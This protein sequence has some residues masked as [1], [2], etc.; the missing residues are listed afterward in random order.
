MIDKKFPYKYIYGYVYNLFK[1][2]IVN[3]EILQQ[4]RKI[5]IRKIS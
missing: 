2:V 4:N 1:R 5:K 3:S